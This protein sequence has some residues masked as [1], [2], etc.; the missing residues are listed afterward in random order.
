MPP[1][2]NFHHSANP[3][4]KIIALGGAGIQ[5]LSRLPLEELINI[6]TVAI[7]ADFRQLESQ[8]DKQ[9]FLGKSSARGWGTAGD[10]TLGVNIC[11][12]SREE[13]K[14]VLQETQIAIFIL[15][16]GGGIGTALSLELLELANNLKGIIKFVYAVKPFSFEGNERSKLAEKTLQY[17]ER[18]ADALVTFSNNQMGELI[19]KDQNIYEAF[20]LSNVLVGNSIGSMIKFLSHQGVMSIGLSKLTKVF[21]ASRNACLAGFGVVEGKNRSQ[22]VLEEILKSPLLN[23]AQSSQKLKSIKTLIVQISGGQDLKL[24]EIDQFMQALHKKLS[25]KVEIFIG[26]NF[27]ENLNGKLEIFLLASKEDYLLEPNRNELLQSEQVARSSEVSISTD[28]LTAEAEEIKA[29]INTEN[30]TMPFNFD[31]EDELD[32]PTFLRNKKLKH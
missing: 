15:G 17:L 2:P 27:S 9:I 24:S 18:Q 13:L 3:K 29:G 12:Q 30:E 14:G 8:G 26:L 20:E 21:S 25:E 5:I 6:E 4:I 10:Y 19:S 32:V 23:F 28:E 7:D 11:K 22:R 31:V 16:L 1:R